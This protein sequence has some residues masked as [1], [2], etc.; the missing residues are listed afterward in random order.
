MPTKV[1]DRIMDYVDEE[2]LPALNMLNTD[3]YRWARPVQV[4]KI[5]LESPD[6]VEAFLRDSTTTMETIAC[7]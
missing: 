5:I 1:L 7:Y 4:A 2:D 3:C 6:H